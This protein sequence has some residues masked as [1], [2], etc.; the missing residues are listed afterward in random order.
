MI[1]KGFQTVLVP[2]SERIT[3]LSV[4]TSIV[5]NLLLTFTSVV[6]PCNFALCPGCSNPLKLMV[7]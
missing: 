6:L 4:I 3:Y 2:N 1:K 7:M 5:F